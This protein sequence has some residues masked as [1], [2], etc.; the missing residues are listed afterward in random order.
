MDFFIDRLI[1][2]IYIKRS[3]IVVGLDPNIE[4]FPRHLKLKL[5][6]DLYNCGKIITYF[7]KKIIDSIY[8]LV[9]IIK[10]QLAYYEK[11]GIEGLKAFD[12]TV[13]YAKNK[14]LIVIADAKRND[15]GST[16]QSYSIGFLGKV[17][18]NKKPISVFDVDAVTVNPFLGSDGILPFIDDVNDYGKG[19]FI[20]VKTSNPSSG[21]IQ[22]LVIIKA[23][24]RLKLYE[25]VANLAKKWA[26]LSIGKSGYSSVGAV[27][28]ATYPKEAKI[29]R[30]KMS[31]MFFLVPGYGAQGGKA[32]DM[33]NF[34]NN[35]GLGAIIASSRK[36]NYAFRY[37][38]RFNENEFD[39]AA[40][41]AVLD[42]NKE[43]NT[44]LYKAKLLNW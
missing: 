1:K 41:K 30:K 3:H 39:V 25:V 28:G 10:P 12:Q 26:S 2:Q 20:L 31:K 16:A 42:M 21:E 24:K 38:K 33:V 43:I 13:R 19:I 6:D 40:R 37:D 44:A 7:N 4:Y 32:V 23:N 27:V 18:L 35:D 14:G 9:P 5:K 8:D 15:I 34:F 36:I 29:L 22:D 17:K 11:Y